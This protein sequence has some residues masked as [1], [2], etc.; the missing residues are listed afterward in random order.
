MRVL[1]QRVS[2]ASVAVGGRTTGAIE[3]GLLL[4]V[5]F[6]HSDTDER[7][8]LQQH[9]PAGHPRLAI[10]DGAAQDRELTEEHRERRRAD[11]RKEPH[12]Q[13]RP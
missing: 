12:Q 13:Q 8:D 11:E 3:R 4:L 1:V 10:L 7:N 2:Q 6:S 9:E 5:G